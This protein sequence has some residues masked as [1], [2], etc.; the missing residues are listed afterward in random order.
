MTEYKYCKGCDLDLSLEH[1][2]NDKSTKDG[3]SFY[4]KE[5]KK[6]SNNKKI[7][8]FTRE[9]PDCKD[10]IEYK[11]EKSANKAMESNSKC[12]KCNQNNRC[13]MRI[14]IENK[15]EI[16]DLYTNKF[17]SSNYIAKKFSVEQNSVLRF[18]RKFDIKVRKI[19]AHATRNERKIGIIGSGESELMD[20][21]WNRIINNA[22]VRNIDFSITKKEAIDILHSQNYVCC[23]SGL[24]L[25]LPQVTNDIYKKTASLDRIDRS[26]IYSKETVQWVNKDINLIKWVKNNKEFYDICK[27]VTLYQI[28]GNKYLESKTID[29]VM[30]EHFGRYRYRAKV[31]NI[32]FAI[33]KD[34]LVNLYNKQKG[35]CAISGEELSMPLNSKQMKLS[36]C[37]ISLDRIDSN[38]GYLPDNIQY[39]TVSINMMKINYPQE[40][41]INYCKLV[42][43][44]LKPRF[45]PDNTF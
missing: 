33:T 26:F 37:N 12:R 6:K 15:D 7:G 22:R 2:T 39:V 9:C 3:K 28:S 43:N 27:A 44:H 8:K 30:G 42:Y 4:C 5:C 34:D 24:P 16:L 10:I 25:S 41:F 31:D 21:F 29:K 32:E 11:L 35:R 14:L 17:E 20:S 36:L 38:R 13:N 40:E 23:L 18:L 1:F 45:E 19:A